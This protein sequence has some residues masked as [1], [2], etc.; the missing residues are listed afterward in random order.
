MTSREPDFVIGSAADPYLLRWWVIP[1]NPLFNVYLH[2]FRRDDDDR[3]LHDHPWASCSIL[4]DGGYF[5]EV[6]AE[7]RHG[8][9]GRRRIW[10]APGS[11]VL[12][13]AGSA[14]RVELERDW[15]FVAGPPGRRAFPRP[16]ITIFL[17]GPRV[18]EWWFHCPKGFVKDGHKGEI[19]R[20]C[21]EP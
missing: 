15:R 14:H 19:G 5:E 16:A 1:R 2:E 13:R 9:A 10:R 4:L 11:V 7:K 12:R 3:A 17:T 6:P 20:G 8:I 18:R 21:G